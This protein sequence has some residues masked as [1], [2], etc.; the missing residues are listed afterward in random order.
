[1]SLQCGGSRHILM[2]VQGVRLRIFR[3]VFFSMACACISFTVFFPPTSEGQSLPAASRGFIPSAFAGIT[4]SYTGL[5]GGR[6]L[7]F[8][9]GVDI[10]FRPFFGLLPAIEIRGTYPVN[11]GAIVGEEH[12]EGGLRVQK[13]IGPLRPYAD[14]LYGRGELNYQNGGLAVPMQAFR[15]IQTTSNV[16]SL[17]AG[18]E[19]DVSPH[20][21]VLFDG[22]AQ[23]WSVPFDPSGATANAGHIT[24]YAG[25]VGMVYR[26][27]WLQHG[28]PAP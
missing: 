2:V 18:V 7:G 4:G 13:R 10:G 15:Y 5:E 3:P 20:F 19:A 21:A 23:I 8:T 17:G 14:F 24:T 9:A 16:L 28:H 26:F 6:N 27:N 25:T 1:M 12:A 11:N 22:Q